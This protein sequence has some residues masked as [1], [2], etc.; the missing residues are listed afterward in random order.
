MPGR[1][2]Y[3]AKEIPTEDG[4]ETKLGSGLAVS[5]ITTWP[6]PMS[7]VSQCSGFAP[8]K[9]TSFRNVS[10]S[11]TLANM[12]HVGTF[13]QQWLQFQSFSML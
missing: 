1:N 10:L 5:T 4:D 11:Y 9:W 7:T 2:Y 6:Y 12:V 13:T 8:V 3:N